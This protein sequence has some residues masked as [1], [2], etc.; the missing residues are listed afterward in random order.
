MSML[1]GL[2]TDARY[3]I[4]LLRRQ[5][6]FAALVVL[7]LTLGIGA[8]TALFS[9]TYGVLIKPLPFPS[10]DRLVVLNETRGGRLPR[11]WRSGAPSET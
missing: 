9:V 3:A 1:S 5:P 2:V 10:G 8:T 7:T 11:F 4:R 6:R